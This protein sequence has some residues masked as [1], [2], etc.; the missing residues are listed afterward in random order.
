MPRAAE[1]FTQN[2]RF[3]AIYAGVGGFTRFTRFTRVC[4]L[5]RVGNRPPGMRA[6]CCFAGELPGMRMLEGATGL[7]CTMCT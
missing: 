2:S 7:E 5:V 4:F 3:Y 6:G 1:R